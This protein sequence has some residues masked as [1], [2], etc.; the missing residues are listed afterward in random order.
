MNVD[1]IIGGEKG[2][3]GNL[4]LVLSNFSAN[5]SLVGALAG[6]RGNS[7]N[8]ANSLA[9]KFGPKKTQVH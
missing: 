7:S 4:N 2:I 3:G 5:Q 8:L 1:K 6:R 9:A